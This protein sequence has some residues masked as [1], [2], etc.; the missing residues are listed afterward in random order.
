MTFGLSLAAFTA[1]H[2]VISLIGILT[3]FLA[4]FAM[5]K[6][7]TPRGLTG[8]FL[9]TTIL[10]SVT[11]FLFPFNGVTPG[12]I[13][14]VLSMIAL[15]IAVV[16][17]YVRGLAGSWRSVYAL[18]AVIAQYFNVFVLFAQLFAKTPALK[19]IAPTQASPVFGAT[20]LAVL[21]IFILLGRKAFKGMR[22]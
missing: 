11:G 15:A 1:V 21:V 3:G 18:T 20:Q 8:L 16:A 4:I 6:G 14:G 7:N 10:T 5:F 19:A 2:V 9:L 22:A 13:L 17:F 12:I